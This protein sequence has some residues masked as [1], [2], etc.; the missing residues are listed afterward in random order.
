MSSVC[1][2]ACAQHLEHEIHR[3]ARHLFG[4]VGSGIHVAVQAA[5]VAAVADVDLQ[6]I[7][8]PTPQCREVALDQQG[9][10]ACMCVRQSWAQY[11][12]RRRAPR[13]RATRL[14]SEASDRYLTRFARSAWEH[15]L[16]QVDG[17]A[18]SSIGAAAFH[19]FLRCSARHVGA[20]AAAH[21]PVGAAAARSAARSRCT[22]SSTM[23]LV[24]FSWNAPSLRKLQKYIFRL[25]SSTHS[26]SGTI[27]IVK[28]AKSGWPVSGQQAGELRHVEADDVVA[29]GRR[30]GEDLQVACSARL[31]AWTGFARSRGAARAGRWIGP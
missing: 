28:C 27:S 17:A 25:F 31:A 18:G 10:V 19:P 7:E 5:L 12:W 26:L 13:Q 24:T 23:V 22:R 14:W 16:I 2:L 21:V 1:S 3:V 15:G 30:V 9:R 11:R 29:L 8:A 6:R 20:D 4:A